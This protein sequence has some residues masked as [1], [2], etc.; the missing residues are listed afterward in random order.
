MRVLRSSLALGGDLSSLE[1]LLFLLLSLLG[2]L[3]LFLGDLLP[4]DLDRWGEDEQSDLLPLS[5]PRSV[6]LDLDLDFLFSD[7]LDFPGGDF[8]GD[9]DLDLLWS[10]FSSALCHHPLPF[11]FPGLPPPRPTCQPLPQVLV[12]RAGGGA[13]GRC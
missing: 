9:L 8:L 12:C 3:F 1:Q 10:H 7:F 6:P 4:L 13:G 2:L 5:R 11:P